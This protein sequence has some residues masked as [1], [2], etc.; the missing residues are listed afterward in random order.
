[1]AAI[2]VIQNS[3]LSS[4]FT[5]T[6]SSSTRYKNPLPFSYHKHKIAH[7]PSK[8]ATFL[9]F[10]NQLSY[11][12]ENFW[13]MQKPV[14]VTAFLMLPLTFLQKSSHFLWTFSSVINFFLLKYDKAE[15]KNWKK[16]QDV[17]LK[18]SDFNLLPKTFAFQYLFWRKVINMKHTPMV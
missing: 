9:G 10:L 3:L 17:L 2:S 8:N 18:N 1:M 12:D 7:K 5:F 16:I 15:S 14:C 13:S 4:C 6:N 11:C